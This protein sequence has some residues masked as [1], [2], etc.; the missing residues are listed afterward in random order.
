MDTD[1]DPNTNPP[2]DTPHGAFPVDRPVEALIRDH[3][4]VRQLADHY[5]DSDSMEVR[6]Q[7]ASQIL[8]ALHTHSRLEES[9]FY[10]GV[11]DIEPGMIGHFE[12]EHLKADDLVATLQ[13]MPM[14]DPRSDQMMR[15]LID[16]TMHH[17]QEEEEQFFPK[18]EQAR[19]DMT[20]IGLEMA[21]FEANLIHMQAQASAAPAHR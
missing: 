19:M 18:L 12:Q 20:P 3:N 5:L 7:A 10:P 11:R 8:Q 14:E 21:A 17:I 16:M 4:L 15:E 6:K 9:V 13:G 1:N 2:H